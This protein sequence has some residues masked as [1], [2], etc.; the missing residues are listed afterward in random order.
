MNLLRFIRSRRVPLAIL[1]SAAWFVPVVQR[2]EWLAEWKAE[3]WHICDNCERKEQDQ[4]GDMQQAT[5]FCLGAFKDAFWLRWESPTSTFSEIFELRSPWRCIALLAGLA[6]IAGALA[7]YLPGVRKVI[8]P[9]PYSNPQNLVLISPSG[10]ISDPFPAIPLASFQSWKN[11][12]HDLF[13]GM[14]FYRPTT[15]RI[16]VGGHPGPEISVALASDNLF[17]VLG[18]P[19]DFSIPKRQVNAER[20]VLSHSAWKKYFHDDPN[21]TGKIVQIAGQKALVVGVIADDLWRLPGRIDA[22]LLEDAHAM[23]ALP[24]DSDGYV[25]A[26]VK[27]SDFPPPTNGQWQMSVPDPDIGSGNYDCVSLTERSKQPMFCFLFALAL[28]CLT[29]PATTSLPLG[30]YSENYT[31]THEGNETRRWIFL[32]AKLALILVIVGLASLDLAH[33]SASINSLIAEYIQLGSSLCGFLFAFRWA[34]HDQRRRCPKCLRLLTHPAYVGQSSRNFLGWNGTE[35]IC[36]GGHGLLHIPDM[37]TSWFSTQRW[38]Y[39]DASWSSL[40]SDAYVGLL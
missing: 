27:A 34:L 6:I 16:V 7:I 21:I 19:A 26:D 33:F 36:V 9:S 1:H 32:A 23:A 40:F 5:M 11:N 10:H 18:I 12:T 31:H 3:L 22:C 29:L 17:R 2:M 4:P 13:N 28:A 14:A 38:L 20:L 24:P 8:L 37:P 25:V 30:E 39:L 15:A 35:L